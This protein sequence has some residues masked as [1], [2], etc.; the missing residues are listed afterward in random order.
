M[1]YLQRPTHKLGI[2]FGHTENRHFASYPWRFC[3]FFPFKW[4]INKLLFFMNFLFINF[5]WFLWSC[6]SN[7]A[8]CPLAWTRGDTWKKLVPAFTFIVSIY[9]CY[10]NVMASVTSLCWEI[11]ILKYHFF[12][13]CIIPEEMGDFWMLIGRTRDSEHGYLDIVK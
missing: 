8:V 2:W 1:H 10:Q 3:C 9:A 6:F 4:L 7:G 5:W 11:D 13:V 12:I